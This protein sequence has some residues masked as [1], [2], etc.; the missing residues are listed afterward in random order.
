MPFTGARQ[1][2]KWK[3]AALATVLVPVEG[4]LVSERILP[5]ATMLAAATASELRLL[6]VFHLPVE[7]SVGPHVLEMRQS[8]LR[9]LQT[10]AARVREQAGMIPRLACRPGF[11]PDAIL[12]E[13]VS[14]DAWCIAMA[15]HSREGLVRTVLGSIVEQVVDR[16][17]V[18][19][20]ALP[21]GAEVAAM[22]PVR[23]ILVPQDGSPRAAA[24]MPAVYDL[25][26]RLGAKAVSLHVLSADPAAEI[27]R[28]GRDGGFDLIALATHGRSVL[29]QDRLSPVA[30]SCLRHSCLPLMV[31]GRTVLRSL[32]RGTPASLVAV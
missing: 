26:D 17:P 6:H 15:S 4:S 24:I 27:R 18:P 14:C 5:L 10:R 2:L 28:Y 20:F 19:V 21:I 8:A 7:P 23:R 29:E 1:Q 30:Q 31:F 3:G 32:E 25:A 12:L 13:A 16:S 11:P 22:S 9:T